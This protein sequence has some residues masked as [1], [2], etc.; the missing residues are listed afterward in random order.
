[1][2]ELPEVE[3]IARGLRRSLVGRT[4]VGGVCYCPKIVADNENRWL[5]AVTDKKLKGVRRRGKNLLLD[6]T[7]GLTLWVQLKMTGHL[8][9]RTGDDPVE[10]HDRLIFYFRDH[11]DQLRFHGM[12]RFGR[13]MLFSTA[14]VMN[15]RGLCDL[16]PDALEIG[17][18]DFAALFAA[19][20]RLIKP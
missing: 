19:H 18:K 16:G 6:L 14:D 7:G 8:Y 9:L 20:A 5:A 15:Q 11:S 4:I 2:P 13:V 17:P 12:R 10:P 3:T 1:M